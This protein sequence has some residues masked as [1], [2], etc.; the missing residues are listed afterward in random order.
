M[1]SA[2][3][4]FCSKLAFP[5]CS[6]DMLRRQSRQSFLIMD[7]KYSEQRGFYCPDDIALY[8]LRE[9]NVIFYDRIN[10]QSSIMKKSINLLLPNF[11]LYLSISCL[12]Y[13]RT[14]QLLGPRSL[15]SP[16]RS[17]TQH[18]NP[19][20]CSL[21]SCCVWYPTSARIWSKSQRDLLGSHLDSGTQDCATS[22]KPLAFLHYLLSWTVEQPHSWTWASFS[23]KL[24]FVFCCVMKH[25][26]L[27]MEPHIKLEPSIFWSCLQVL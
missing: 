2:K 19:H 27:E 12:S 6:S 7:T 17:R 8:Q 21:E 10:Q 3:Q 13:C 4:R 18:S 23:R 11:Q 16:G 22:W 5:A 1:N 25:G 9:Q 24:E 14:S 20:A 15:D 26:F